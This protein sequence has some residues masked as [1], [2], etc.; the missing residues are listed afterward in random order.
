MAKF[1]L[2]P[3]PEPKVT[4]P[5][6]RPPKPE[7]TLFEQ[8]LP[9][10]WRGIHFPTST[11]KVSLSQDITEHK[12]WGKDG[13]D[14]ESTGRAPLEIEA[15]LPLYNGIVP[16]KGEKWG[17]LYPTTFRD[18]LNAFSDKSKGVLQ[19]PELGEITCKPISFEFALDAQRRDG[20]EVSVK[21][22]ETFDDDANAFDTTA[23]PSPIQVADLAALDLDS[24]RA[25][26]QLLVPDAAL[27]EEDFVSLMN[28]V[29]GFVDSVTTFA[30]IVGNKPNQVLYRLEQL[31]NSV[32]RARNA[33]TWP[34][35]DTIERAKGALHDIKE[36][37]STTHT[38]VGTGPVTG[39]GGPSPGRKVARYLTPTAM[40]ASSIQAALPNTNTLDEL[41]QLNP[42]LVSRTEIGVGIVIRYYE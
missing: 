1:T 6:P 32:E 37:A 24:S 15:V 28:K 14:V 26:L 41:M 38:V 30:Q 36:A 34:I 8:L 42:V 22:V 39:S 17:V 7:P 31:Q 19:H 5:R 3:K 33:L 12:Y 25:D 11:I 21:W 40:T 23:Q 9:C 16:G 20:V 35:I 18:L 2:G 13:A 29:T 27:P 10:T 4:P